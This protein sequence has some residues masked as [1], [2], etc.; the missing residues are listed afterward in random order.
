MDNVSSFSIIV[1]GFLNGA[2]GI[3]ALILFFI[4]I[5]MLVDRHNIIKLI[6]HKEER[7]D[8]I[9][10]DYY[11]GNMNVAEAMNSLKVMLSE[12]KR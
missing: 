8:A 9:V 10:K 12:M 2:P 5:L 1:N 6:L 3:I 4:I 11:K 7:I